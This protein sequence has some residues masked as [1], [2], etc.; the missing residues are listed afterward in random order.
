MRRSLL[1][2]GVTLAALAGGASPALGQGSAVQTHGSCAT[3]MGAAGVASPCEDGSAVLFNPAALALQSSVVGLG[4]TGITTSGGFTYDDEFG[5]ARFD[6]ESRTSSVPFGFASYRVSDR[7]A[8][9]IGVFAPYGLGVFWDEDGNTDFEGRFVSYDTELSNIYIQ[10][11]VSFAV[12]PR[13]SFGAGID[14][15]RS[16]I[17]INQRLDLATTPLPGSPI[18]GATFGSLGIPLGTDFADVKLS[19][20]GSA[21]TFHVGGLARITDQISVGA[22]Y[23][24]SAEIDFE[25]DADFTPVPTNIRLPGGNPLGVQAGTPLDALLTAQFA[26]GAALGDQEIFTS[27]PVPAQL[28]LGVALTPLPTLRLVGDYQWTGWSAWEDADIDFAGAAGVDQTLV[29]QYQDTD[30]WRFG[31]EL[32]ASDALTVRGGFIY[33]TAAQTEFA[34]SPLLPEAERNYYSLGLGYSISDRLQ[35][36]GAYQLVDQSSRRGRVRGRAPGLTDAQLDALNVGVFDS[37]AH[38]L[39]FTVSYQ[40]GTR[41]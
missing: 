19:G 32:D 15:I 22:R 23:L 38:V 21:F 34:V 17:K 2:A 7:L 16:A 33:N 35:I 8:A 30:T 41:R 5:G 12:T 36:D 9:G 11:T 29:L 31:G 26:E 10:P 37:D 14:Y 27:L 13:I 20:D 18:P 28:V 40:F 1:C 39:N 6:R 4:W 25:G 24:H 3:A